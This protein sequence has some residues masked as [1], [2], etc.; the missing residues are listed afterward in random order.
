MKADLKRIEEALSQLETLKSSTYPQPSVARSTNSF[1]IF[2]DSSQDKSLEQL[3]DPDPQ[4]PEELELADLNVTR[5]DRSNSDRSQEQVDLLPETQ[6]DIADDE[7]KLEQIVQQIQDLYY[8]GPIIDGWL[9]YY[10]PAPEPNVGTLREITFECVVEVEDT[11]LASG[12]ESCESSTASYC[13]C[14]TDASGQWSYPCPLEQLPSVSMA[15]ARYQKLQ[16]LLQQ[17]HQLEIRLEQNKLVL[18]IGVRC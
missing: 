16:Q 3:S 6:I 13:V 12:K 4:I 17:K 8:E 5:C 2:L 7:A 11:H 18:K 14:G 15:I 9:E 1:E 10:P